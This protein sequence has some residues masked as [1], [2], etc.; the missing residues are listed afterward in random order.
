[1]YVSERE[2]V[3]N[4]ES[5]IDDAE[6]LVHSKTGDLLR[7]S[8]FIFINILSRNVLQYIQHFYIICL[9]S[10]SNT[11]I[12]MFLYTTHTITLYLILFLCTFSNA[13]I[14]YSEMYGLYCHILNCIVQYFN[15][16][17]IHFVWYMDL[18][19]FFILNMSTYCKYHYECVCS[20]CVPCC[21]VSM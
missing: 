17:Y 18:C 4:S 8:L 13:F 3:Y 9:F 12:G 21:V 11:T 20:V 16:I 2:C 19:K 1:M 6:T 15:I 14:I 7:A 5:R 10:K